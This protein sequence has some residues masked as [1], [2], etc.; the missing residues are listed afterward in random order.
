MSDIET[1]KEYG[2]HPDQTTRAAIYSRQGGSFYFDGQGRIYWP[3]QKPPEKSYLEIPP[4][5]TS[6]PPERPTGFYP[7]PNKEIYLAKLFSHLHKDL[8]NHIEASKIKKGEY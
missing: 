6:E 2:I 3:I 4:E 7:I 5:P 1:C 8:K